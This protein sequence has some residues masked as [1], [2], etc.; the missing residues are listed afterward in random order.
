MCEGKGVRFV[1]HQVEDGDSVAYGRQET[2]AILGEDKIAFA[3]DGAEQIRELCFCQRV[4]L[5][6][7]KVAPYMK[8]GLHP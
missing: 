5:A 7:G 6:C 8:I 3:I 2:V 1:V 4:E